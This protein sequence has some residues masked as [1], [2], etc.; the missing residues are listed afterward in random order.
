MRLFL[1]FTKKQSQCVY[2]KLNLGLLIEASQKYN[3]DLAGARRYAA[4]H[5][6][7]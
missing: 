4:G 5:D 6:G 7:A 2:H 1:E 3:F